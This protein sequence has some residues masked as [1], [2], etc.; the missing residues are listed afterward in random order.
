MPTYQGYVYY[1]NMLGEE[2][3][4]RV[5]KG[6]KKKEREMRNMSQ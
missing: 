2:G 6:K 1:V 4:Y 5:T 3:V